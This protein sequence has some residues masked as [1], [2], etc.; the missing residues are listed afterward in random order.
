MPVINFNFFHYQSSL[1]GRKA[2]W[3]ESHTF[4]DDMGLRGDLRD[5]LPRLPLLGVCTPPMRKGSPLHKAISSIG[6]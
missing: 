3:L 6:R 5:L 2:S 1:T 4:I